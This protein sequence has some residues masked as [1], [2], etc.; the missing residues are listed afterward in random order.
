MIDSKYVE[1]YVLEASLNT[2][3]SSSTLRFLEGHEVF[4]LDEY[5]S[6]V[7]PTISER[8]RYGNLQNAMRRDQAYRL[9]RGLYASNIGVYRDRV[10]NVFLVAAKAAGGAVVSHHSAL[11]AHG[12]AHSPLR[13]VYFTSS[14]KISPFDARG[15]RFRRIAPPTVSQSCT[16]LA[17][18]TTR[19]RAGDSLVPV[20]TKER[21]L[22]DCL[23]DLRLAGGLEELLRS[24]GGFTSMAA[25][26]VAAYAG[27][28][29][30]PTLVSRAGWVMDLFQDLWR[31]DAAVLENMRR[32]LG[33]G[34]YRLLPHT[35]DQEFVARWRL[36][37]PAS[38][39]YEEWV[40]G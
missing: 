21:T 16:S 6:T 29:E 39:P 17:R 27:L 1:N 38:A 33:K 34:T 5:S 32:A 12:V 9:K 2:A 3:K 37:V 30:S 20:T 28:L 22:V 19:V 36:Y 10:P 35:Q 4:T 31:V 11:E 23:R 25:G 8:T 26:D 18:Y 15:Y 40:R 24:L 13:T 14:Q 7:D